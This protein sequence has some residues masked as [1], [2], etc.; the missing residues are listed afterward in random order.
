MTKFKG[1]FLFVSVSL[2]LL[3]N[4]VVVRSQEAHDFLVVKHSV[5]AYIFTLIGTFLLSSLYT[6][7]GLECFHM[8]RLLI[9]NNN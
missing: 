6:L 8:V 1:P 7:W 9:S 4:L 3:S 5:D 2:R